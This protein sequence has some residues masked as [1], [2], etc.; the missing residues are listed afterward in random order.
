MRSDLSDE[1]IVSILELETIDEAV[2]RG[3]V[4][5][6]RAAWLYAGIVNSRNGRARTDYRETLIGMGR[7][8]IGTLLERLQTATYR[9]PQ[10]G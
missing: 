8:V 2:M 1:E 3:R 10:R 6:R 7:R 4:D 5:W 9:E